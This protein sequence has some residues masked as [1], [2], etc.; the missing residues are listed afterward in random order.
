MAGKLVQANSVSE[1]NMGVVCVSFG[2]VVGD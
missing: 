2:R 1:A